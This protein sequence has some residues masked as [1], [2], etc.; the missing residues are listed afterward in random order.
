MKWKKVLNSTGEVPRPRHGHR[1]VNIK[2]S[3]IVFGGGNEG[4]VDELHVY[5]CSKFTAAE[6]HRRSATTTIVSL[7][8]RSPSANL[9]LSHSHPANN[10][11]FIPAVKGDIPPGC[12]AYGFVCDS[13]RLL[14]FGGMVEYGKYTNELYELKLNNWEWKRLK[15]KGPKNACYPCPRLGHSFTLIGLC[16]C[17]CI[18]LF[19]LVRIRTSDPNREQQH[20]EK[21]T[22]AFSHHFQT[23]CRRR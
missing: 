20:E 2:D 3:I 23:H 4:I 8:N 21:L 13:S 19:V 6:A 7:S 1:S 12:A 9:F 22:A 15:P 11:W 17:F 18:W 5:N 16:S 14:V 10:N